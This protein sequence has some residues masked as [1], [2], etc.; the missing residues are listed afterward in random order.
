MEGARDGKEQPLWWDAVH[1][2]REP[3]FDRDMDGVVHSAV[4]VPGRAAVISC[5]RFWDVHNT[6]S[7]VVVQEGCA[8]GREIT[9]D[10]GPGD[11]RRGP[12]YKEREGEI[13]KKWPQ[14]QSRWALE[15]FQDWSNGGL[16]DLQSF[17][18][19]LHLQY[20]SSQHHLGAGG[21]RWNEEGWPPL[22]RWGF[23]S[24]THTT[25]VSP[26]AKKLPSPPPTL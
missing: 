7:L 13:D 4:G 2:N 25:I 24:Y 14:Y 10:F 9:A 8:L 16:F 15:A 23:C 12:G 5:I 26:E 21:A 1:F 3:T 20:A 18:D 19:A 6:Q 22:I 11:F 17:S